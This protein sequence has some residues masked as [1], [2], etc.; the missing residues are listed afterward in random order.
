[1]LR[2]FRR[3]A[4][5]P[6]RPH[7]LDAVTAAAEKL[8]EVPARLVATAVLMRLAA[9]KQGHKLT[10]EQLYD[11]ADR[12]CSFAHA[13]AREEQQLRDRLD[14]LRLEA[15]TDAARRAGGLS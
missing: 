11:L 6:P 10:S 1:M 15:R 4:L 2:L 14:Y 5:P 9:P 3:R 8:D 13:T 7:P 12:I